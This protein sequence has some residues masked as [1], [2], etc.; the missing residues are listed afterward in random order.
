[1]RINPKLLAFVLVSAFAYTTFLS[2]CTKD[3]GGSKNQIQQGDSL[4]EILA[5][6]TTSTPII[7]YNNVIDASI[8]GTIRYYLKN[9]EEHDIPFSIPAGYKK[10]ESWGSNKYLNVWYYTSYYDSTTGGIPP[11]YIDGSWEVDHI[12]IVSVN[13]SDKKYGFKVIDPS[14]DWNYY[15][16]TDPVTVVSF[17]SN[18]DTIAYAAYVFQTSAGIYNTGGSNYGFYL[19]DARVQMISGVSTYPL[20]TGQVMDIPFFRY[21]WD[22][23]YG[24]QL[25]ST[26]N[27]STLKL[28]VTEV[29]DKYFDATFSGKVW[30]SLQPDT[31]FIKD[32][33]MQNV[34]LPLKQ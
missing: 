8:N 30:S 14:D 25:D 23:N 21:Y 15:N 4:I 12:T 3:A 26:S 33:V 7:K 20:Y 24:S 2:S 11:P 29:T 1:M 10:L 18:E 19:F 13:C 17:V 9:G 31:L 27:G 34:L 5:I 22:R 16:P 28:T 32:G 6:N